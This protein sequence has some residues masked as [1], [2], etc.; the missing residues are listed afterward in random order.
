MDEGNLIAERF[1]LQELLF[2]EDGS[3]GPCL[4]DNTELYA[5]FNV[6][7]QWVNGKP[8]QVMG[9]AV[10]HAVPP[11]WGKARQSSCE[12]LQKTKDLRVACYLT[13]SFLAESQ[14]EGL[15]AGLNLIRSLLTEYWEHVHPQLI[16]DGDEDPEYRI[17]AVSYLS[18]P[19][20]IESVSRVN[21]VESRA[22]GRYCLK[23]YRIASGEIEAVNSDPDSSQPEM[24]MINA[25]FMDAE[26]D[27]LIQSRRW[28]SESIEIASEVTQF[29]AEKLSPELVP[30]LGPLIEELGQINNIYDD[31]LTRRNVS[32][33]SESAEGDEAVDG[34]DIMQD[35]LSKAPPGGSREITSR[36]EVVKQ[37]DQI[38]KY[39]EIYEP[40]SPVPLV[41]IR[42]KKWV[43]MDFMA[44]M[45]DM[46]PDSVQNIQKLA[47]LDE[48]K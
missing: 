46:S 2:S 24:P 27:G 38:C 25:A 12:L 42:A 17:N 48:S 9:D 30:Q 15:C 4:D 34:D 29:F 35:Q 6:I 44:I 43:M 7:E 11:N 13:Q 45:Q 21:I 8:E 18:N 40:S 1:K 31:I 33:G 39:Y 28:V 14:F 10:I 20:F 3:C 19:S 26:L 32:I 47:G 36:D 5:D 41:L 22:V 16:I 37:I 23:D